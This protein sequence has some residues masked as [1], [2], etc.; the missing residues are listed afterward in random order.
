MSEHSSKIVSS[1]VAIAEWWVMGWRHG[2]ALAISLLGG[3]AGNMQVLPLSSLRMISLAVLFTCATAIQ[4]QEQVTSR[5]LHQVSHTIVTKTHAIVLVDQCEQDSGPCSDALYVGV[6]LTSG[7]TVRLTGKSI[8]RTCRLAV[9]CEPT[10]WSFE[11]GSVTYVVKR[12]FD[13]ETWRLELWRDNRL[14]LEE[15]GM[16]ADDFESQEDG[17]DAAA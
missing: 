1:R 4:S 17:G 15:R 9:G 3:I 8:E 14:E 7:E 13:P 5:A 10:S 11:S 2:F 6:D 12:T 16:D